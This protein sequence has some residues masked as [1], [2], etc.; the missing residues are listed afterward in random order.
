MYFEVRTL[1]IR[2][3]IAKYYMYDVSILVGYFTDCLTS[4]YQLQ[5]LYFNREERMV[6][7]G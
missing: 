2:I 4:G 7:E 3:S 1:H 5:M 6:L